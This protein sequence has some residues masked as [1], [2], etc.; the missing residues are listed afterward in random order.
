MN[1]AESYLNDAFVETLSLKRALKE[2]LPDPVTNRLLLITLI[3]SAM[4]EF[5]FFPLDPISGLV[6]STTPLRYTLLAIQTVDSADTETVV[7]KFQNLRRKV[8]VQGSLSVPGSGSEYMLCLDKLKDVQALKLMLADSDSEDSAKNRDKVYKLLKM[9]KDGLAYPLLID[10]CE[11]AGLVLPPC[12]TRLPEELKLKTLGYLSGVDIAKMACLC[13]ELRVLASGNDLWKQKFEEEFGKMKEGY[14]MEDQIDY[15]ALFAKMWREK[16]SWKGLMG[17][18]YSSFL[19]RRLY[20][21][22]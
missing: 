12:F 10:L 21:Y 8:N 1:T 22:I 13:S 19:R 17:S 15:R 7:L 16:T 2:L 6:D 11:K 14:L 4:L 5:G 3:H 20:A 9:V 18:P